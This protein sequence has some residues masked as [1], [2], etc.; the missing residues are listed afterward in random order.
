MV[1]NGPAAL[2][3]TRHKDDV[4]GCDMRKRGVKAADYAA[5][6]MS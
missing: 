4:Q 1:V 5:C 6:G 3:S 2:R